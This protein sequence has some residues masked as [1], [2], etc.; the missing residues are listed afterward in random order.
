MSKSIYDFKIQSWDGQD[1]F[2]GNYKG[3]VSLLINTTAACGNAPQFKIIEEI[4]QKYKDQGFEVIAIPTNQYCG[5][6][7]TYGEWEDGIKTA[8][9]SK[10]HGET[11]YGTTYNFSEILVSKPG[12]G[13][14]KGLKEGEVPHELFEEIVAQTDDILM[15][16]NFEKY[17]IDRDGFIIRKYPNGSLLDY[18]VEAGVPDAKSEYERICADIEAALAKDITPRKHLNEDYPEL[19][20]LAPKSYEDKLSRV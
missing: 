12:P 16:G 8:F 15:Y 10:N 2:L 20:K 17:L 1:D 19:A 18:A 4:Y 6:K 5:A 3:K 11:V 13:A 7:V 14:P 9:D